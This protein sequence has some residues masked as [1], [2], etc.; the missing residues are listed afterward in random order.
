MLNNRPLTDLKISF[1]FY[2]IKRAMFQ[3]HKICKETIHYRSLNVVFSSVL[4][5]WITTQSQD[6]GHASFTTLVR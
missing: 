5:T 6:Q 4:I 1:H 2:Y 3:A